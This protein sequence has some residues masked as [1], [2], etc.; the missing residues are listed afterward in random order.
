MY[1]GAYDGYLPSTIARRTLIEQ[2][3]NGAGE[4][5]QL[6]LR[7]HAPDF[8]SNVNRTTFTVQ[9]SPDGNN[10]FEFKSDASNLNYKASLKF[11]AMK[12][13]TAA[14]GSYVGKLLCRID[15]STTDYAIPIYLW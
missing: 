7:T 6:V 14:L 12:Y 9:S 2:E 3:F 11:F 10:F 15:G 13:S 8:S 5:T 1:S 4:Y